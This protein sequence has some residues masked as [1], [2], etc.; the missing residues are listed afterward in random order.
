M[1]QTSYST[2]PGSGSKTVFFATP[3]KGLCDGVSLPRRKLAS[4][5]FEKSAKVLCYRYL[6]IHSSFVIQRKV[7]FVV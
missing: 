1:F 6:W 5:K 2:C 7:A 3:L 4:F